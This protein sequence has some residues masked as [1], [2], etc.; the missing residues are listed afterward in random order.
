MM[1]RTA[2]NY[3]VQEKLESGAWGWFSDFDSWREAKSM[4]EVYEE[5]YPQKKFRI[6]CQYV[7]EAEPLKS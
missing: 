6:D 3:Q 2:D 5:F 7:N 4:K 1:W